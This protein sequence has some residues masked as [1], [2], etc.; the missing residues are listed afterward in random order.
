MIKRNAE[1][2]FDLTKSEKEEVTECGSPDNCLVYLWSYI[3][4]GIME[5]VLTL[6]V[7]SFEHQQSG[8]D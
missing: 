8:V 5:G 3:S 6:F 1:V 2:D 7:L 4:L